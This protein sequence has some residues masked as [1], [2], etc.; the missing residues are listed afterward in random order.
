MTQIEKAKEGEITF[1]MEFVAQ[2]ENVNLTT[3]LRNV[4]TGK[5]VIIGKKVK[6]IGIGAGLRTKVNT[7]IG[8]SPAKCDLRYE[9]KKLEVAIKAGT[10]TIMDLSVGGDINK[11]R[12]CVIKESIVPVGTVP[13]YQ[14]VIDR[15]ITELSEKDFLKA[16][17]LHIEDGVDFITVHAGITKKALPFL[18]GRL[19]KSVSRG[20]SFIIK[21]MEHNDRENPLYENFDKI[22][23]LAK[24]HDVVLSLGDGLRPGCLKD[25]TDKAQLFELKTLGELA[26]DA[27]NHGV[28]AMIEGPGHLPITHIKKNIELE[29]KICRGA[30]FYVLG[31]LVTDIAP[32]YDHITAAIGGALA[33]S[34]GADFLCYVTKAEHLSLPTIDDVKE[35]VIVTRIAA[36][37]GDIAKLPK[38]IEWDNR[39]S[40]ARANLEWDKMLKLAI[41]PE[42]AIKIRNRF[43]TE[44]C[45]MCDRYCSLKMSRK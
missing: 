4:A 18:K 40:E 9:L 2:Q 17:K 37:V 32:G 15:N 44:T 23:R 34:Y 16:I 29:K 41:N 22:L 21:W 12:K 13:I 31:P 26:I 39:L 43:K 42:L 33:A 24:H 28:Q 45:A 36:H 10:D 20:G 35:A 1:E 27:L 7:N 8:T 38:A 11:I 25:A 5:V 19:M 6:A 14:A 30:P 3:L